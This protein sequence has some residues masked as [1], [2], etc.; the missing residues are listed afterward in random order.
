MREL[1]SIDIHFLMQ[2]LREVVGS[3]IDKIYAP[4][5]DELVLQLR[6][7]GGKALVRIIVPKHCYLSSGKDV[8]PERPSGWC[9]L[10]RSL[11]EGAK[12]T[13][14]EQPQSERIITFV[15][16]T[17]ERKT[18]LVI[19]LFG[20]GNIIVVDEGDVI[21]AVL[22]ELVLKTHA[23]ERG[24]NYTLPAG[25]DT[26][27]L[28]AAA[29]KKLLTSSDKKNVSSALASTIGLGSFYALELCA[30]AGIDLKAAVHEDDAAKL[31][32]ALKTLL[33]SKAD[34][35]VVME[36]GVPSDVLP[37]PFI[38]VPE[39]KL[40]HVPSFSAALEKVHRAATGTPAELAVTRKLD[41]QRVRLSRNI[42]DQEAAIEKLEKTQ[43]DA[44]HA[45][46][47]LYENYAHYK[48][49]L[50]EIATARKK[51]VVETV[52][53]KYPDIKEYKAPTG[54]IVVELG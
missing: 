14:I 1:S 3:R 27:H 42:E 53:K 18:R 54:D 12:I 16:E 38:S 29:F 33:S 25:I 9:A 52:L 10:L 36:H 2:E 31:H 40:E 28:D 20:K 19:E 5:W 15:L 35:V 44:Q 43:A 32:H 34:A 30:R 50:E 7:A 21:R 46:E 24:K 39:E 8:M 17:Q 11:V 4:E 45:G 37:L 13:A 22:H 47:M 41:E 26:F 48:V 51:G 6:R 23:V 49:M